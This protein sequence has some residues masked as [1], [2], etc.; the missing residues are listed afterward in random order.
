MKTATRYQTTKVIAFRNRKTPAYPNAA[1]RSYQ[2]S[3]I[4]N[5]ALTA[6]TSI[7]LVSA[8]LF[9]FTVL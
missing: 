6:A 8:L 2:L 7:A 1:E 5:H 4:L 3:R 9:L